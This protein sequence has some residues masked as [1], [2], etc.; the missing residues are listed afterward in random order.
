MRMPGTAR[1][2][3]AALIAAV[4]LPLAGAAAAADSLDLSARRHHRHHHHHHGNS[5]AALRMFGL[6]AGTFAG[7]AAAQA[8]RDEWRH[9]YYYG[10]SRPYGYYYGGPGYYPY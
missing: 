1:L 6:M 4:T 8:E 7:I 9:R 3:A 2:L 10:Y 5:A